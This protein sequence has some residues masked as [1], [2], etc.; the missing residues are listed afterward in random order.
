MKN[1]NIILRIDEYTHNIMKLKSQLMGISK[2]KLI[3]QSCVSYL[4]TYNNDVFKR[5]LDIYKKSENDRQ[6]MIDLLF[7]YYRSYGFPYVSLTDEQKNIRIN[8]VIRSLSPLLDNNELQ[9]NLIGIDLANSFHPNMIKAG[10]NNMMS[11]Y[12]AFYDDIK[13][14]DCIKRLLDLNNVPN[15]AG[16][17]KILRTRNG[18]RGVSNFKPVIARFLYQKYVPVNGRVLDPCAGYSGRLVG[19]IGAN[20]NIYYEGIDQDEKSAIGNM[21]CASF[22]SGQTDQLTN[23]RIFNFTFSFHLGCA[24][25][26]M[27]FLSSDSYDLIFT[28]PPYFGVEHYS[29]SLDQSDNKN[30]T[31]DDWLNN[32]LFAIIKESDRLV[33]KDGKI[34]IN[35]KNTKK[36]Q[37]ADDLISFCKNNSMVLETT[38]YMKLPN[39]EYHRSSEQIKNYHTEP[40]FVFKKI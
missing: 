6:S 7:E 29:D 24:E 9:H 36:Y 5:I 1:D 18:V 37:I 33:K 12:Q 28:S 15:N 22:F 11:P 16:M 21:E 4:N 20:K 34:I 3:R 35:I 2:S 19:C 32:F 23:E 40:I 27:K 26:V 31:Y 38:Y 13:F 10:Y 39:S 25:N 14:K 8:R 30:K 17:R